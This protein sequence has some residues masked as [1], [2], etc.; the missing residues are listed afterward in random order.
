MKESVR[1]L[2]LLIRLSDA[3]DFGLGLKARETVRSA[4]LGRTGA[5]VL[6]EHPATFT[7]FKEGADATS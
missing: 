6:V 7:G 4:A 5:D 2:E 3:T 1:L